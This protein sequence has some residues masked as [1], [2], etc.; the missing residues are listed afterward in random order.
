MKYREILPEQLLKPYVKC[1]YHFESEADTAIDDVVFP[2]GHMEII[3]NMGSATWKTGSNNIFQNTPKIE[4]WGQITRPLPVKAVGSY[5]KMLGVRFYPHTAAFFMQEDIMLLN[6]QVNDPADMLGTP[7][8]QL[9][10]KL[11]EEENLDQQIKL[12]SQF[13]LNRLQEVNRKPLNIAMVGNIIHQMK[14][15][16]ADAKIE[17]IARQHLISSRYLHKLFL[18]YTGVPPKF[19][20]KLHRFQKSLE[21]V[22]KNKLSL[23]AI[24]YECGYF[25]QSHFIREFKSFTGVSPASYKLSPYPVTLI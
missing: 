10:M 4:L 5:N 1:Y 12:I 14:Q 24:A 8:R 6:N 18:Q 23:T 17:S 25:D 21:L 22:Q 15:P 13:L 3:F 11:L 2:G 16:D 20:A 19:Y 9:H 7:I